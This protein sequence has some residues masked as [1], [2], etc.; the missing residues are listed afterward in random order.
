[1]KTQDTNNEQLC[2]PAQAGDEDAMNRLVE[3]NLPFINCTAY[4]IWNL[5]S[6]MSRFWGLMPDDLAQEGSMA[7]VKCVERF[8]AGLGNKFLTYAAP[9]SGMPCWM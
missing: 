3:R 1:M 6:D 4:S 8:D 2:A 5:R 9:A 7:L